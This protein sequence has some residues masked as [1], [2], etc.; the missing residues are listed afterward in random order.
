MANNIRR[1]GWNEDEEMNH[2][3]G[4]IVDNGSYPWDVVL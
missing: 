4:F 3:A 1:A 2:R